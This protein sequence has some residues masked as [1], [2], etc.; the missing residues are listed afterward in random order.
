LKVLVNGEDREVKRGET[1]RSLIEAM[2]LGQGA[3]AAEINKV[4][5]PRREHDAKLLQEGDRVEIVSLVGGG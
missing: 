5:V 2:G 4:L 3:C 1:V